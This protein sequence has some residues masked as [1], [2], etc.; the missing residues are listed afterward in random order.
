MSFQFKL[1]KDGKHWHASCPELPGCHTFGETEEEAIKNL[2]DAI[3]IYLED[4]IENQSMQ[5][6]IEVND[7]SQHAKIQF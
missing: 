5:A 7:H 3:L 4:D 6:I 2:K 1:K